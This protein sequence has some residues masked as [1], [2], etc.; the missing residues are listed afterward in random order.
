MTVVSLRRHGRPMSE[1]RSRRRSRAMMRTR[2]RRTVSVLP[3]TPVAVVVLNQVVAVLDDAVAAA[4]KPPVSVA[5][6]SAVVMIADVASDKSVRDAVD[7]IF[8]QNPVV[9]F[10]CRYGGERQQC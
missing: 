8:D 2:G 7:Q 4:V 10:G 5:P 9:S 1:F 6:V 3:V